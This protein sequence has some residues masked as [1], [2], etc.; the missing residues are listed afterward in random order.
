MLISRQNATERS[1]SPCIYLK[2][3]AKLPKQSPQFQPEPKR[4]PKTG[5]P[6]ERTAAKQ[7][8]YQLLHKRQWCSS[9]IRTNSPD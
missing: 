7:K 9:E 6:N 5:F 1:E 8:S 4:S 2:L 3:W